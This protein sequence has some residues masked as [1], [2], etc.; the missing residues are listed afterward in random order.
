MF[1]E[2]CRT[3]CIGQQCKNPFVQLNDISMIIVILT[4]NGCEEEAGT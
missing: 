1:C 3:G 4:K 2:A